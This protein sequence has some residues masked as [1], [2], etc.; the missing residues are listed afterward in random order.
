MTVRLL[1]HVHIKGLEAH[2]YVQV[3]RR[4]RRRG[5]LVVACRWACPRRRRG[6]LVVA[7]WWGVAAAAAAGKVSNL[8]AT[9][10]KRGITIFDN[11]SSMQDGSDTKHVSS[12]SSYNPL[13]PVQIQPWNVHSATS[14]SLR[15]FEFLSD[16]HYTN[17]NCTNIRQT[18]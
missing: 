17:V 10:C 7:C 2:G 13:S 12:L 14:S 18:F 3:K 6:G 15:L 11:V 9:I 8:P 1:V 4:R 5:G 16:S